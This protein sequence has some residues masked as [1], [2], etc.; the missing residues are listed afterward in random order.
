MADLME[1]KACLRCGAANAPHSAICW[2]CG[3]YPWTPMSPIVPDSDEELIAAS[4]TGEHNGGHKLMLVLPNWEQL[5]LRDGDRLTLGRETGNPLIDAALESYV[6][7]SRVHLSIDVAAGALI[8]TD[9]G[10]AFGTWIEQRQISSGEVVAW[11][12]DQRLRLGANCY[13]KVEK[14]ES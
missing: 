14:S 3:K 4:A 10:S 5:E 11:D 9:V 6:D 8:V 2:G 7:V 1:E 12:V 13:L